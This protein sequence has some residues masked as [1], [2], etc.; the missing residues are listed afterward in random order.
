MPT[1]DFTTFNEES[2]RNFK[3][4]LAKSVSPDWWKK[5]KIFQAVRGR[6]AQTIRACP[7]MHDWLKSGWYIVANRDMEVLVGQDREGLADENYV[8]RD[9]SDSGYSSPSHPSDQ[10]DNA[11][12]YIKNGKGHVKD[13]FKMRNPW[14]IITPSGYSTFYLEPFLFQNDY[15]ATWQGIIDTD[16]F[17]TNLDN[18]QIIFYPKTEESFTITEGTPLVQV[19]PY[20]REEWT[21]TYQLKDAKTWHENRSEY[22]THTDMP[23][24]DEYGR[25]EY[26]LI[27]ASWDENSPHAKTAR[28]K[29]GPYRVEGYWEEKGQFYDED[30]P[31]PECPAHVKDNEMDYSGAFES[32][33]EEQLEM[34]L[35]DGDGS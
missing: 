22:T 16:K 19:I 32:D 2:L 1:I 31:P 4:V 25:T 7:A 3:P 14:N 11:F 26:D 24:M 23:G 13:A 6:R 33:V 9:S 17:N 5:M 18:S 15:F 35:G 20:K 28:K 27:K 12:D 8:T 10:F 30:E 29:L 34:D 21:A